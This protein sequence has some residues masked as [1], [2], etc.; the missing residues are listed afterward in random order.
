MIYVG[1][2]QETSD[3]SLLIFK[4]II[5]VDVEVEDGEIGCSVG[6]ICD[7]LFSH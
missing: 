1:L 4:L 7:S 5:P 3:F 2:G 6:M